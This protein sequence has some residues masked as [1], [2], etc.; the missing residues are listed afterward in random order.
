M[1]F[2][3]SVLRLAF[4]LFNNRHP[5]S[6]TK[7]CQEVQSDETPFYLD[8]RKLD[9][10]DAI[11]RCANGHRAREPVDTS[12]GYANRPNRALN[13]RGQ[14]T[15]LRHWRGGR[16]PW[17]TTVISSSSAGV[18]DMAVLRA[19]AARF[20]NAGVDVDDIYLFNYF[21]IPQRRGNSRCWA[22]W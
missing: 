14:W 5:V 21:K 13:E 18:K 1:S 8:T 6:N 2:I 19:L 12:G 7:D 9:I 15:H 22:N 16:F 3:L 20:W 10:H 4:K 11:G 17:I